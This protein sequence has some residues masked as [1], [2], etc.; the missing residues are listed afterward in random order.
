MANAMQSNQCDTMSLYTPSYLHK[1]DLRMSEPPSATSG[2]AGQH[3]GSRV[4]Q[5]P[6]LKYHRLHDPEYEQ[7]SFPSSSSSSSSASRPSPP[8]LNET[9]KDHRVTAMDLSEEN[10]VVGMEDGHV[11]IVNFSTGQILK[12]FRP[13]DRAVNDVSVDNAGTTIVTCSDSGTV[14]LHYLGIE[15]EKE[16]FVYMNDPVKCVCV[17]DDSLSKRDR[18]FVTGTATGQ[19][20]YYSQVWFTTKQLILFNGDDSAVSNIT[21]RGNVIAWADACQVRLLDI[22]SKTAICCVPSPAGVSKVNPYPCK[23]FWESNTNLYIGWADDFRNL[24]LSTQS[25]VA[26]NDN[27]AAVVGVKQTVNARTVAHWQ[28]DVIICGMSSFDSDHILILGYVPPDIKNYDMHNDE[29]NGDDEVDQPEIQVVKKVNGNAV[30][31]NVISVNGDKQRGPW[32]YRLLSNYKC[33][34]RRKNLHRWELEKYRAT[35]GG[36]KGMCPTCYLTSGEDFIVIRVRDIN[37]RVTSALEKGDIKEAVCLAFSDRTSL[38]QYQLHDLMTL[39]IE[40]LLDNGNADLAAEECNALIGK[41]TILWERWI[42]AFIV[43]KQLS[44][45]AP[46]IPTRS[47]RLPSSVYEVVLEN[48]LQNDTYE[49]LQVVRK[50]ATIKPHIFDHDR[51]LLRLQATHGNADKFCLEAEAELYMLAKEY[52]NAIAAYLEIEGESCKSRTR[53]SRSNMNNKGDENPQ[54]SNFAHIFDLIEREDLFDHVKHKLSN[55]FRLSREHTEQFLLRNLE[56]L[57][58]KTVVQQLKKFDRRSLCWYLHMI[59]TNCFDMYNTEEYASYH[60]MQ[61]SLYAEEA[62]L[63][64]AATKGSKDDDSR[65]ARKE[66]VRNGFELITGRDTDDREE[67]FINFLKHSSYVPLD[68]AL[69][70]CENRNPPLYR[71][72]VYILARQGQSRKALGLLLRE[73]GNAVDAIRFVE[74]NDKNLWPVLVDYSLNHSGFLIQLLDYLGI[75][76]I[77]PYGIVSKIPSKLHIPSVQKKMKQIIGQYE[78]QVFLNDVCNDVM[79]NDALTLL[80]NLNHSQR[81]AIK[82]YPQQMRCKICSR[83]LYL[84]H[85]PIPNDPMTLKG[86]QR[87]K[88][89]LHEVWGSNRSACVDDEPTDSEVLVFSNIASFHR[90]CF[91]EIYGESRKLYSSDNEGTDGN[92]GGYGST[93]VNHRDSVGGKSDN[94]AN[95]LDRN[96]NYTDTIMTTNSYNSV[97][98]STR[99]N[100]LQ[101]TGSE[102][103]SSMA[104][105]DININ[106][107][108]AY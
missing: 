52:G 49:F 30:V 70:E 18:C 37:D 43:R 75:C 95:N 42:L 79:E 9:V 36:S 84:P 45:I 73:D 66:N 90:F 16:N 72:M 7:D 98:G 51:L 97:S 77:D 56:K 65:Q 60:K 83:P 93:E 35:R 22:A 11:H 78:F 14:T 108:I 67:D 106:S 74:T 23:L 76:D 40:D 31:C 57:T 58:I 13:H 69:H 46:Y 55:M 26:N 10:L 53:K 88:S 94:N 8:T 21:W 20:V 96:G 91:H 104:G 61:I 81:K 99:R 105:G 44:S 68:E 29:Q 39:Y 101:S 59:F 38:R 12:S 34:N 25:A 82:V 1:F 92:P 4:E 63:S 19:L 102:S 71:E 62:A 2:P 47:P 3:M 87:L 6:T 5:D 28:A 27:N 103:A 100:N 17:E 33:F 48:Y 50:W 15:G 64:Y 41:D 54:K 24:E 85:G 89:E 86:F 80:R 107:S 32:S